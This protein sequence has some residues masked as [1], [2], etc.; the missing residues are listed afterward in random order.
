MELVAGGG[1]RGSRLAVSVASTSASASPKPL[2]LYDG[3]TFPHPGRRWWRLV[4]ILRRLSVPQRSLLRPS[5]F[6][7]LKWD[8]TLAC[9]YSA[10]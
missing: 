10:L 1:R 6:E 8:Q 9:A 5:L 3:P 4:T 7:S 2:C